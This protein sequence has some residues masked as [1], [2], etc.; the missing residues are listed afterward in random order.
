MNPITT[1]RTNVTYTAEGCSDLPAS[2]L[3]N[4]ESGNWE[5]ET[6]WELSDEE[7]EQIIK[8]RKIYLY[9]QGKAVPPLLL[10]TKPDLELV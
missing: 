7:V 3:M 2:I 1:E 8:D 4:P 5:V 10:T 9:I 6:C